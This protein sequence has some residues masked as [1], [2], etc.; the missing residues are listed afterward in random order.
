MI[1]VFDSSPLIYFSRSGALQLALELSAENYITP[2]VYDEVVTLGRAQGYPD[3]EVT[4]LVI[5]EGLLTVRTPKEKS[6]ERFK[7]L[8]R[9]LHAGEMEVLALADDLN[10]IAILDDRIGREIGEMFQVKVRG[11][12][13]ILFAL[14]K[15]RIISKEKAKL[16]IRDMIREGFRIGALQYGLVLD[17]LE[18]IKDQKEDV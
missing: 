11:S 9:G 15:K 12:G 16:I 2:I 14:V 18:Q 4:Y 5:N 10:G 6:T 7:G 8:H 3:A 17:L 1:L 13:F